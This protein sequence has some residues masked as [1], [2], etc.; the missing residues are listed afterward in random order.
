MARSPVTRSH[1]VRPRGVRNRRAAGG[2]V[3]RYFRKRIYILLTR[4]P[5]FTH[6]ILP[7]GG[8]EDGETPA[9]AA[10][11]E[12]TEETGVDHLCVVGLLGVRSRLSFNKKKWTTT[13]YFLFSSDQLRP[14][15]TAHDQYQ[16]RWFNIDKLPPILWRE[17]AGLISLARGKIT[18]YLANDAR[19]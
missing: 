4:Q 16:A 12:I 13:R 8:V 3:F 11:R 7:K 17:Q 9:Q 19:G 18:K 6:Y 15:A 14:G 10:C 1:Y 2:V 5:H